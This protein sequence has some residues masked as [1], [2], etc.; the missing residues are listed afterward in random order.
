MVSFN[1]ENVTA[2]SKAPNRGTLKFRL[3][4]DRP[5]VRFA[6]YL[7]VY[8]EMVDDRGEAKLYVYPQQARRGEGDLPKD[9]REGE[10]I[11]FKYYSKVELPYRDVRPNAA[12]GTVSILLYGDNGKI[13]FQ[14][15][16]DK[17]EVKLVSSKA[18]KT[19]GPR[20]RSSTRRRAL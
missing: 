4:K 7:F 6:G 3:V 17:G 19:D 16:F 10:S 1:A 18:S 20:H 14:R 9:Y 15:G 8:V 13:V 11:A 2:V 5:D 12:L